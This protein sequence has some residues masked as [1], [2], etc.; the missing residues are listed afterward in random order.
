MKPSNRKKT[1]ACITGRSAPPEKFM[2]H[3][4]AIMRDETGTAENKMKAFENAD[5]E[6]AKKPTDVAAVLVKAAKH[7]LFGDYVT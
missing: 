3:V 1:A 2:G 7:S 6:V 5:V 4:E